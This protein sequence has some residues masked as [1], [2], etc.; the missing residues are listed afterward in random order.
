M[1][2]LPPYSEE[3]K[4]GSAS[5]CLL[6]VWLVSL[7]SSPLSSTAFTNCACHCTCFVTFSLYSASKLSCL[8]PLPSPLLYRTSQLLS[9]PPTC[10]PPSSLL[11]LTL[12]TN[13]PRASWLPLKS[14]LLWQGSPSDAWPLWTPSHTIWIAFPPQKAELTAGWLPPEPMRA[15]LSLLAGGYDKWGC[16]Q[17]IKFWLL[18]LGRVE[19]EISPNNSTLYCC[20][21]TWYET[22]HY[23]HL[24]VQ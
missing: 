3:E 5:V 12:L 6:F 24:N 16:G 2:T 8:H 17:Y 10:L 22:T 4:K 13:S 18:A 20:R 15:G 7:L 1:C 19:G 11:P 21:T 14:W 23:I 9:W